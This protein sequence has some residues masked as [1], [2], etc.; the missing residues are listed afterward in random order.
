MKIILLTVFVFVSGCATAVLVFFSLQKSSE[1][2]L[3]VSPIA[4]NT[5]SFTSA[6]SLQNAPYLSTKG[7]IIQLSGEVLWESRIATEPSSLVS[8]TILQQGESLITGE[9]GSI[10]VLFTDAATIEVAN[11]SK[12]NIVQ[13]LPVDI[14][15]NQL[16]GIATYQSLKSSVSIRSFRLLTTINNGSLRITVDEVSRIITVSVMNGQATVAYNNADIVSQTYTLNAGDTFM[17]DSDKR[18]GRLY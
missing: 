13:T 16:K 10:T 5:P 6:F 2:P 4:H 3:I 1:K 9:D 7:I 8:Q 18:V 15:F 17:F 12:V 11:N 14:V